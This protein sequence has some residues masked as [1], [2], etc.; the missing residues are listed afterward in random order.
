MFHYTGSHRTV[1]W[2]WRGKFLKAYFTV[3]KYHVGDGL[4]FLP[5]FHFLVEHYYGSGGVSFVQLH[6]MVELYYGSG[7]FFSL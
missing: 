2:K 1:L 3:E 6:F 5:K 7:V 4:N